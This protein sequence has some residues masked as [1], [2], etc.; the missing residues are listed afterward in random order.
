MI[1]TS[2]FGPEIDRKLPIC[3]LMMKAIRHSLFL[4]A[5]TGLTLAGL[6]SCGNPQKEALRNVEKKGYQLT[7]A[8]LHAAAAAGDIEGLEMFQAAGLAVDSTD[9]K[10]QTALM[11]AGEAGNLD[12]VEKLLGMGADPR[13][14][15]SRGRDALIVAAGKGHTDVVRMLLSR[16]ADDSVRDTEGWG[17]LS[18][19]AYHG[20]VETVKLLGSTA[21]ASELDDA[22]LVASFGK[23]AEVVN[24]LLDQGANINSR[25]PKSKTPL[26]IA[27]E[28]GRTE[29]VRVLLQ[30]QA[31]PYAVDRENQTAANLAVTA[32]H[33]EIGELINQP[34]Q[35]GS[36]PQGETIAGEMKD[37]RQALVE[38]GIE[39]TLEVPTEDGSAPKAAVSVAVTAGGTPPAG[40]VPAAS[41][42]AVGTAQ[43]TPAPATTIAG[44]ATTPAAA[45]APALRATPVE[46]T[47]AATRSAQ[48]I[49]EEA[50]SKPIVALNGSTIH[51]R[52]PQQAPVKSMVLAAYHEE[53]LPLVV[54]EVNGATASVR[55]LD[56]TTP[57]QSV[58]KGNPVPGTPYVVKEVTSRFIDSKEGKGR[59]VDV[60]R[61]IV[62]DTSRG[63]THL[64]VKDASGM[65][66][67]SYAILT[68]PDSRYRYVVK[69]GDVFR[70][71]Q[72]EVGA[73]DYQ[74][75]EIRASA[76]VIK[77]LSTGEIT[78]VARDGVIGE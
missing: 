21:S 60:S 11:K 66:S 53:S 35:W 74:V 75:L 54:E 44:T 41:T 29:I 73:K 59:M 37:A 61:V 34:D 2:G 4:F 77:D 8:D 67:D 20:Q 58:E 63:S 23:S 39:E 10:G 45:P 28:A 51:S 13:L 46:P 64:L 22:L 49:K 12:G 47:P 3:L 5:V 50:K 62:E 18:L 72:P 1:A 68:A 43:K 56:Q 76:V 14:L 24:A 40:P 42:L 38:N 71:T 65:T 48:A 78:T 25:S 6:V 52:S 32:G 15:D 26:M 70:T 57:S 30:N 7:A 69:T 17:A 31:N 19:A 33:P 27:S 55:R 36:S 9:A 16:G